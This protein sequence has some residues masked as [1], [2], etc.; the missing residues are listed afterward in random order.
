MYKSKFK[1]K[2]RVVTDSSIP[3]L[4]SRGIVSAL[5]MNRLRLK[6]IAL[7]EHTHQDYNTLPP[8]VGFSGE[9]GQ[10]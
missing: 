1:Y 3:G 9:P 7:V 8:L 2:L 4:S 5:L 6:L 10:P